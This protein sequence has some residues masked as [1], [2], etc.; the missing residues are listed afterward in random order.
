MIDD[1]CVVTGKLVYSRCTV[2]RMNAW[3][4]GVAKSVSGFLTQQMDSSETII[5]FYCLRFPS[6]DQEN[7]YNYFRVRIT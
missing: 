3:E 2:K 6:S 5:Q 1:R 4:N 7:E